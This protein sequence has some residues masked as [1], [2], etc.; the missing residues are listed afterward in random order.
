MGNSKIIIALVFAI[1]VIKL[2]AVHYYIKTKV[3]KDIL[4]NEKNKKN[5]K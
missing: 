2:V 5:E 3:D 1:V 4:D